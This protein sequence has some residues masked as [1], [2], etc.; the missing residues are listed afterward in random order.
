MKEIL[1]DFLQSGSTVESKEAIWDES[2]E[3]NKDT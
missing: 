3:N 2:T 1:P